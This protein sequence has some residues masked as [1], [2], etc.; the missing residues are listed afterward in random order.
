MIPTSSLREVVTRLL[1]RT[2]KGEVAWYPKPHGPQVD[3]K[4]VVELPKSTVEFEFASPDTE[5]DRAYFFVYS[6][7]GLTTRM[8]VGR[9]TAEATEADQQD[10]Q[11]LGSLRGAINKQVTGWDKVLEELENVVRQDGMIGE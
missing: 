1:D 5:P 7:V 8:L 6:K 3:E 9:L 4:Y 11:L 10:W 2:K